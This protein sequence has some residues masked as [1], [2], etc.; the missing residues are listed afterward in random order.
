MGLIQYDLCPYKKGKSGHTDR[1]IEGRR[2]EQM[3]RQGPSKNQEERHGTGSPS[4]LWMEPSL[5]TA[6]SHSSGTRTG[7]Q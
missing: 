4:Q 7:T 6:S 5:Q 2:H 3:G 1:C